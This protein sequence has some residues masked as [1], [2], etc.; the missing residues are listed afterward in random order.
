MKPIDKK[1]MFY[2][3]LLHATPRQE[4]EEQQQQQQQQQQQCNDT[5]WPCAFN[6]AKVVTGAL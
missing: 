2:E 1:V 6:L 3:P 4:E 5:F